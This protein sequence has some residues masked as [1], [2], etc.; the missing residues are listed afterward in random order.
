VV[1]QPDWKET[2]DEGTR[3][4]PEPEILMQDIKSTNN[5]Q[6][7]CSLHSNLVATVRK[8]PAYYGTGLRK[9]ATALS[10]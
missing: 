1:K 9:I 10:G 6:Q 4:A 2:E 8:M 5:N 3:L 7:Q